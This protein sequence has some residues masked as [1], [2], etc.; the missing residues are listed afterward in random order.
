MYIT[1]MIN[2]TIA[3]NGPN[4]TSG[5]DI[6]PNNKIKITTNKKPFNIIKPLPFYKN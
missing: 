3:I 2:P 5:E 4:V 6:K 1:A